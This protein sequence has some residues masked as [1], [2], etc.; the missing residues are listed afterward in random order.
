[1]KEE[2][3][4]KQKYI[5]IYSVILQ[6]IRCSSRITEYTV[7]K[8]KFPPKRKDYQVFIIEFLFTIKNDSYLWTLLKFRFYYLQA[9]THTHSQSDPLWGCFTPAQAHPWSQSSES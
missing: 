3:T 9:N 7:Q 2:Q 4:N 1:M 6:N 8:Y 5:Y